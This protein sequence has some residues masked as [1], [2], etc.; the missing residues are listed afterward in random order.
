MKLIPAVLLIGSTLFASPS[1]AIE[2]PWRVYKVS[3][4]PPETVFNAG[5]ISQ[6]HDTDII[7]YV[8]GVSTNDIR[9]AY[10]SIMEYLYDVRMICEAIA[11]REPDRPIYIYS[12][13]PT[14]DFFIVEKSLLCDGRRRA[15][16]AR[17]WLFAHRG[18]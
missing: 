8:I 16:A 11:R 17:R 2:T 13:R 9:S 12:I 1:H 7:R 5:F 6:E 18:R 3:F 4:L 10:V 15:G 14:E